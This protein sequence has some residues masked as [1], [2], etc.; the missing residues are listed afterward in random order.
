MFKRASIG[1]GGVA[2]VLGL[3]GGLWLRHVYTL[4]PEPPLTAALPSPNGYQTALAACQLQV[5]E[6]ELSLEK[7]KAFLAANAASIAKLREALAQEWLVPP[8]NEPNPQNPEF[9][10][11]RE[12]ARILC[13]G[14]DVAVEAKNYPEA[15]RYATD[16]IELGVLVPRGGALMH[17][18]VGYACES[19]GTTALWQ[20]VDRLDAKTARA[21]IQRLAALEKRRGSFA[22]MLRVEKHSSHLSMRAFYGSNPLQTWKSV[23][24]EFGVVEGLTDFVA[25]QEREEPSLVEKAKDS[26]MMA[27]YKARVIA[28]G[29]KTYEQSLDPWLDALATASEKPWGTPNR[30]P[31][32]PADPTGLMVSGLYTQAELRHLRSRATL[33][34]LQTYLS[35]RVY[36]LEKG[37]Y[38]KTLETLV[39]S[40]VLLPAD[41][42]SPTRA[43]LRYEN[44]VL[45][46]V[47]K[48]A[49]DPRERGV[50]LERRVGSG[51]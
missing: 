11:F 43:L 30:L 44:G 49:K 27:L 28:A 15:A 34:M 10:A 5:K 51:I 23:D 36:R 4:P 16:A 31:A 14:S 46:S 3:A 35:L 2:A 48:D 26:A 17:S 12:E 6:K 47:G 13:L 37:S 42:F 40:G 25:G 7:R 8:V 45:W 20:Y 22:E 24:Q 38:P 41:P 50:G 9:A 29:P 32:P 39:Q 33:A 18:L 19:I 21:T 1:C